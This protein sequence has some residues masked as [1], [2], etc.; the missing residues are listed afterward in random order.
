MPHLALL[1]PKAVID[2]DGLEEVSV[3][4]QGGITDYQFGEKKPFKIF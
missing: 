2:R 3:S 4:P 1:S